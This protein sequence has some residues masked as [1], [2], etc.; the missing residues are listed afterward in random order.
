MPAAVIVTK[1]VGG[2]VT[3]YQNQTALY[4]ASQREVRLHECRSACTLALSLPNV[5][6]YPDSIL[7]FHLA[8]DPRN[9]QPNTD[10]SQQMFATYPAAVQARL[11][12]LT[13]DYKVLRGSE[14]IRLGI[15]DCNAP[16]TI[17]PKPSE[18]QI[19]V[20][21]AAARKQPVAAPPQSSP[22]TPVF[23]SLMGK[24]M[25]VFGTSETASAL[26]GRAPMAP[27][28]A[29]AKQ[30]P[31][32]V[33]VAEIP[34]PPPRPADLAQT[35]G[36]AAQLPLQAPDQKAA[37][38]ETAG[39]AA[40]VATGAAGGVAAE[41]AGQAASEAALV[42]TAEAAPLPPP[43]PGNAAL[44]AMRR[45]ARIALPKLITGAQPILP[46]DFSAY[47]DLDR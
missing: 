17:E 46:P 34:L 23:A 10:V 40:R 8:Y 43:R 2:F 36:V 28:R 9:H 44:S 26:P 35:S 39:A 38:Q 41:A 37:S 18:P 16:K 45:L 5:C 29:V 15:R 13:R 21:S 20:A 14:L 30:A 47:A 24:V 19:M 32:Q 27:P 33:L 25:S 7:K 12:T 1:D 22:E 11:G 6:V 42:E 31:G 3:E 4:R